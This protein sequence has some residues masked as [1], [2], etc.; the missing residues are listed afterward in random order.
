[1]NP[2]A[3]D[4]ILQTMRETLERELPNR[5]WALGE[6]IE[7]TPCLEL[8]ESEWVGGFCERGTFDLRFRTKLFDEAAAQ[9]IMRV[10]SMDESTRLS[11]AATAR[12][13]ERAGR[14]RP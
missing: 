11:A 12:W 10:R 2:V 5:A 1:M 7:N 6:Y 8:R 9:F 3:R 14:K 13:L 4:A